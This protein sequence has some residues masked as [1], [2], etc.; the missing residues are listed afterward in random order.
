M[1]IPLIISGLLAVA[2]SSFVIAIIS[3][4]QCIQARSDVGLANKKIRKLQK[5][6]QSESEIDLEL[7]TT[8]QIIDELRKRP[9]NQFLMLIPHQ[10]IDDM[11]VETH[12]CNIAPQAV[13]LMLKVAYEGVTDTWDDIENEEDWGND[14]GIE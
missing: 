4:M 9:N 11:F 1:T 14:E 2:I 7:A 13:L 3:R 10:Q 12:I 5:K 8:T 6:K